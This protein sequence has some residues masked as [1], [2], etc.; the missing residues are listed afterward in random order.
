MAEKL[1]KVSVL[2]I[3]Y[4]QEDFIAEAIES[5]LNQ[6]YK[7]YEIVIS[8]DGSTD[9]TVSI[10]RELKKKFPEK[11]K[12]ITNERNSGITKNCNIALHHCSGE[13]IV[14]MGGD[15]LIL[16]N[17]LEMQVSAFLDNP[18]LAL[19]YHP[20]IVMRNGETKKI[21]GHRKKDLVSNF[22]EM[23]GKF[24]ADIPGP[25]TM[26]RASAIPDYGFNEDIKTASDWLFYIDVSSKGDVV[27]LN[28]PLAV[29][30]QHENNIGHMYFKYSGD[31]IKT[32]EIVKIRYS[33]VPGINNAVY[34][35]A[36][37]FL[38]GVI[39]RALEQSK[40]D[41]ARAYIKQLR[42]YS[43][44]GLPECLIL[45]SLCPGIGILLSKVKPFL[46]KYF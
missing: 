32:M 4:N 18:N 45:I 10:L 14:L 24:Q 11:I 2:I 9:R 17:K 20:C 46:K 22:I 7:N 31:F 42:D 39:Y 25:A 23:V 27:R 19:C 5:V 33:N 36:R 1:P 28:E 12:L 30:R 8:D 29:Y 6:S 15:D 21:V 16:P 3:T 34:H 35:G 40:P 37:R 43:K 41:I 38:I 26:V 44:F 13:F